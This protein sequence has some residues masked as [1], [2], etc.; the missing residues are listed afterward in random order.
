MNIHR[1][2]VLSFLNDSNSL[3][4]YR[5]KAII[6]AVMQQFFT[7]RCNNR[8]ELLLTVHFFS[9][10]DSSQACACFHKTD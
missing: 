5:K 8:H 6:F 2:C 10:R 9:F 7:T 1:A 4:M 3:F